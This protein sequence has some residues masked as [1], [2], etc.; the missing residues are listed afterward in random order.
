[1]DF[2]GGDTLEEYFAHTRGDSTTSRA[3]SVGNQGVINMVWREV[4]ETT[5]WRLTLEG[6]NDT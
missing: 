6:V 4:D 3:D 5:A 2:S 1:M